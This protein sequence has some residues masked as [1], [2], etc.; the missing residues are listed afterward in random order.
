MVTNV[1]SLTGN[2]LKDWLIQRVS[3]IV[4]GIYLIVL[5]G[6]FL[7]HPQVTYEQW[8]SLMHCKLFMVFNVLTMLSLVLH[9]WIGL[10]TVTTDYVKSTLIRLPLQM[11]IVLGLM[12]LLIWFFMILWS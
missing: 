11:L 9:A 2:G 7:T 1:T 5:L 6:F 12:G 4:L 10:W 3:A 8:S